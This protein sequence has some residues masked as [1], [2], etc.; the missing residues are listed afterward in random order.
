[1]ED[2]FVSRCE[3]V[4]REEAHSPVSDGR[5][6]LRREESE[7]GPWFELMPASE[8]ACCITVTPKGPGDGELSIG[9]GRNESWFEVW[10]SANETVEFLRKALD[11]VIAGRYEEFVKGR[12]T[13][14]RLEL[15]DGPYLFR[16]NTMF[17]R[18]P[19][20][21]GGWTRETYE[22]Y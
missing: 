2:E 10:G 7:V 5:A 8:R 6:T 4:I 16:D 1:M 14:G 13:V 20:K 12:K 22:A 17:A 19:P 18:W 21:L 3:R 9:V 15:R 11:A